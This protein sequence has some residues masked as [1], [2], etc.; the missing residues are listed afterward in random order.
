MNCRKLSY[1]TTT[2][3]CQHPSE[4]LFLVREGFFKAARFMFRERGF[5]ETL[6]S[7]LFLN[8]DGR[9][10]LFEMGPKYRVHVVENSTVSVKRTEGHNRR[11][12]ARLSVTYDGIQLLLFSLLFL[13][14][15]QTKKYNAIFAVLFQVVSDCSQM[16]GWRDQR[17]VKT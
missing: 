15:I 8:V 4:H 13:K 5:Y 1:N 12:P 11:T 14:V 7:S 17:S 9:A 3:T 16:K 6:I 10:A 2:Q